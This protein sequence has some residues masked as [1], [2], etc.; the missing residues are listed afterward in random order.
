VAT[1]AT[2]I[3]LLLAL[4]DL[5]LGI[6]AIVASIPIQSAASLDL[7]IAD[8]T[9][10]KLAVA[11]TLGAW[12]VRIL[13]GYSRPRLDGVAGAFGAYVLVITLSIV[14]ARNVSASAGEV[15]R[16]TAALAICVAAAESLRGATAV[17]RLTLVVSAAVLAVAGYT[18][19]QV[20]SGAG[21]ATFSVG[22]L[23]RAYGTFGEPNP[24]AGYL[25]M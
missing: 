16:W 2:V 11:A 5:S 17:R 8:I 12:A 18:A 1:V 9:W 3:L 24:L 6:F 22:G 21:P 4:R 13:A 10:T 14:E 15:H 20:V 19:W 7:R 25:E 23:T